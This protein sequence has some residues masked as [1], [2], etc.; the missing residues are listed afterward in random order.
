MKLPTYY[1]LIDGATEGFVLLL[2]DPSPVIRKKAEEDIMKLIRHAVIT[3]DQSLIK[4][5]HPGFKLALN[6]GNGCIKEST[7][8]K[9][10]RKKEV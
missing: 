10:K 1:K 5:L 8:M 3:R 7:P 6:S 4:S 9:K 2:N